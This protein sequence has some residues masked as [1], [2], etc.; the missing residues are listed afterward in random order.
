MTIWTQPRR[1]MARSMN[2]TYYRCDASSFQ[3]RFFKVELYTRFVSLFSLI[4]RSIIIAPL[5][6]NLTEDRDNTLFLSSLVHFLPTQKTRT[7]GTQ[8]RRTMARSMNEQSTLV[9][10]IARI[11]QLARN[12]KTIVSAAIKAIVPLAIKTIVPTVTGSSKR[13]LAP[14]AGSQSAHVSKKRKVN[15]GCK[16]S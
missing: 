14:V 9:Y 10:S 6:N 4:L 3:N 2:K 7:I 13:K 11:K 12:I 8:P 15:Q 1:M 16:N 5:E